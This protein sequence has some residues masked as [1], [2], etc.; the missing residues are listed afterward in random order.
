MEVHM[1]EAG[2]TLVLK[3]FDKPLQAVSEDEGQEEEKFCITTSQSRSQYLLASKFSSLFF[4]H[5]A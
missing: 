3:H 5:C 2:S 4:P 1:K